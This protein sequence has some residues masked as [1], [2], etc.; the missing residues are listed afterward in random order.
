LSK[1][2]LPY[3][4]AATGRHKRRYWFYRRSGRRIPITSPEGRRLRHGDAG[5][6]EAY[7]HI[8]DSFGAEPRTSQPAI[9]TL[10]HLIDIYRMAPEFL[11]L[12]HGR[13][14]ITAAISTS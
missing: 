12:G 3:L 7:E 4:W 14:K 2:D 1:L 10:A 8:H 11:T 9:G 13:G 5:F 6:L